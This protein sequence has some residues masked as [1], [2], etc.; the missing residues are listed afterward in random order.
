V[1]GALESQRQ[2]AQSAQAQVD[3]QRAGGGPGHFADVV[4]CHASAVVSGDGRPEKEIGVSAERLCGAV[5]DDVGAESE[6]ALQQRG[7]ERVVD[8]GEDAALARECA[9]AGQVGE[10]EE[11][12]GG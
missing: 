2:G 9:E 3:L 12:V 1:L 6:R 10:A 11:G 4:Q 5:D 7:A 8:D